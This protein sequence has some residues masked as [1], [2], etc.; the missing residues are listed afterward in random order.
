MASVYLHIPFCQRKCFY[1]SFAVA[2]AQENRQDEYVQALVDEA[3]AYRGRKINTIYLGGGTPSH[4]TEGQLEK[5]FGT[6]KEAFIC[7][8]ECEITVEANPEDIDLEKAKFLFG[9]GVNRV[10][11]GVQ[12]F[13]DRYLKLLGRAHESFKALSAFN[14]LRR[15][16][17]LNI[18]VDLMYSFP[19]QSQKEIQEDVQ[20]LSALGSEH[21]SIYTLTVEPNSR[22]YAQKI[23][24]QDN[25][26]QGKQYQLVTDLLEEY[27]FRQYE[28][29]NFSRPGFESGHNINYWESGNY[30]GLGV[31]AHSHHDGRR[32]WNVSRF[33]EYL[34]KIQAGQS[35]EEGH[36]VLSKQTRLRE[37]LVFGLRMNR[38]VVIGSLE[39]QFD[40]LLPQEISQQIK[41]LIEQKLLVTQEN[42]LQVTRSGRLLL[43][44][45]AV[46]LI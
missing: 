17:F 23:Q 22:F 45:I 9:L 31:S 39:K 34:K 32:S 6:I 2:I 30:F 18:N 13:N 7:P 44:E 27:G 40:C 46:K 26:A 16:G 11:L 37:A 10:S 43:D 4:L 14:D 20:T 21:V 38:G 8:S 33:G 1:C 19:G 41:V 35:P 15:G 29:S 3:R 5:V 42:R 36:E 28:V 24:Q 25:Q 12:T